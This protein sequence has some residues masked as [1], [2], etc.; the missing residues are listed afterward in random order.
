MVVT[1][2]AQALSVWAAVGVVAGLLVWLWL[3]ADLRA[4]RPGPRYVRA[5]LKATASASAVSATVRHGPHEFPL[6]PADAPLGAWLRV[7][8]EVRRRRWW[9]RG[10]VGC[11]RHRACGWAA[12]TTWTREGP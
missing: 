12:R 8:M 5:I 6:L 7:D 3:V 2:A 1:G 10:W 9:R 4:D 11:S